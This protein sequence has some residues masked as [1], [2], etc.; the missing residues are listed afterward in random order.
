[1]RTMIQTGTPPMQATAQTQDVLRMT[2]VSSRP[3]RCDV[4][5][6]AAGSAR[7]RQVRFDRGP[8]HHG[9][10]L[11]IARPAPLGAVRAL[12]VQAQKRAAAAR[13]SR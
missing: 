7:R 8:F 9:E 10:I 5:A 6:R 4:G 11:S 1:M 13:Y 12:P 2:A 3:L